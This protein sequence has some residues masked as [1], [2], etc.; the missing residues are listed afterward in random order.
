MLCLNRYR[1]VLFFLW[2]LSSEV[3]RPPPLACFS[4]GGCPPL[5]VVSVF[6]GLIVILSVSTEL[7][8]VSALSSCLMVHVW[9]FVLNWSHYG[10]T[11]MVSQENTLFL[12]IFNIL[13]KGVPPPFSVSF[14]CYMLHVFV[15]NLHRKPKFNKLKAIWRHSDTP[16]VLLVSFHWI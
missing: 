1:G 12:N 7:P 10:F 15:L 13:Y 5:L 16:D 4:R 9:Q 11:L 6:T 2:W 14:L 8:F 3:S